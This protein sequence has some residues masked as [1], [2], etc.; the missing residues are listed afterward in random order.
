MYIKQHCVALALAALWPLGLA[1]QTSPA[2]NYGDPSAFAAVADSFVGDWQMHHQSGYVIAGGMTIPYGADPDGPETMTLF[3][4]DNVL[5]VTHPLAQEPLVLEWADE[6]VWNFQ[7][8]ADQDGVP[9]PLLSSQDIEIVM[10]C[11]N[12]RMARLIGE[13][14]FV[15]DGIAMDFTYRLMV[16]NDN[17][18][19]GIMHM[20]AVAHGIPVNTWRSVRLFR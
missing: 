20:A 9:E 17:A 2:C 11:S 15:V 12:D 7:R 6:P 13:T 16:V 14:T 5:V 1:A 3:R 4:M 19:Y 10:G 18:M 8:N